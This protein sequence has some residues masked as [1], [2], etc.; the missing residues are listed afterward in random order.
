MGTDRDC[1]IHAVPKGSWAE[2]AKLAV[3]LFDQ[4]NAKKEKKQKKHA[5]FRCTVYRGVSATQNLL[6]IVLDRAFLSQEFTCISCKYSFIDFIYFCV[7]V[8]VCFSQMCM[9]LL[10]EPK[11]MLKRRNRERQNKKLCQALYSAYELQTQQN[12]TDKDLDFINKVLDLGAVHRKSTKPSD[13]K[14]FPMWQLE[15]RFTIRGTDTFVPR[16]ECF[17]AMHWWSFFPLFAVRW[18]CVSG[19]VFTRALTH[20]VLAA[21]FMVQ[22]L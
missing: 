20:R 18:V 3:L 5:C 12:W 8:F 16:K 2:S 6:Y 9:E 1:Y 22:V 11:G 4:W 15:C 17:F 19:R 14:R 10:W 21:G 13:N 7:V